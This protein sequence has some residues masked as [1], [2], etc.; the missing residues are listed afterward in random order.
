MIEE[1]SVLIFVYVYVVELFPFILFLLFSFIVF[2]YDYLWRQ[3]GG[4]IN[5]FLVVILAI[6]W[7]LSLIK[8]IALPHSDTPF[9]VA[10]NIDYVVATALEQF[11]FFWFSAFLVL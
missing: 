3:I 11:G 5:G 8:T 10:Q 2:D 6:L 9:S 1:F 4:E 7:C